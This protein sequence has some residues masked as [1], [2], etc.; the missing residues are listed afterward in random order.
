[1]RAGVRGPTAWGALALLALCLG[2][3]GCMTA[4]ERRPE[5]G[6]DFGQFTFYLNG[7]AKTSVDL[8]FIV[9]DVL[10]VDKDGTKHAVSSKTHT[11]NSVAVK[12]GQMR[13]G[14]TALPKGEY[15]ALE[16]LVTDASV[17]KGSEKEV[18]LGLPEKKEVLVPI[19]FEVR[20]GENTTVFLSWDA[21]ASLVKGYRFEPALIARGETPELVNLLVFVSNEES[22]NVSVINRQTNRVAATVLTGLRPRGVA[23]GLLPDRLRV[24]VANRGS[25]SISVIDPSDNSVESEVPIR[26][27]MEPED[28]AAA[29]TG[30]DSE[31]L[32]VANFA[33]DNVSVIDAVSLNERESV[34]VGDG[35][36][37]VA[38][39]PPVEDFEGSPFLST[40]DLSS[41]REFLRLFFHV[42]V[43]NQNSRD[44]TVLR[45]ERETGNVE[46]IATIGVEWSPSDLTVD[47]QRGKIYVADYDADF[48]SVIDIPS[49]IRGNFNA[50][51]NIS[52]V[53]M[54]SVGVLADPSLDRI[55]VLKDAP[56]EIL[57]LRPPSTLQTVHLDL[58]PI[59]GTIRVGLS[60]ASF[61]L[62]TEG[63][64]FYVVNRGSDSVTVVNKTSGSVE[65]AIPVGRRPYGIAM[66]RSF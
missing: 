62:D 29:R 53:G 63:R 64:L 37:A 4:P 2:V 3:L 65:K 57:I 28:V 7:P 16:L 30:A 22:A 1:V 52:G 66:F 23:A 60:P 33:S 5:F 14:E 59:V 31:L 46:K 35:P 18:H 15:D 48:L 34:D 27:G 19:K 8:T 21:D 13:L 44:I 25:N 54:F 36:F 61:I 26:F 43:A 38:A 56:G 58:P 6:P 41:I 50:V 12:A 45:V 17:T 24:Y 39:D 51:T 32:F 40:E 42:Y 10:A 47:P 49:L 55:Y 20:P 9:E 11:V